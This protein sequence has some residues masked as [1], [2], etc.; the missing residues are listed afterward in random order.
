LYGSLRAVKV[1]LAALRSTIDCTRSANGLA[2]KTSRAG[3][4][5][6]TIEP[7][8]MQ[9]HVQKKIKNFAQA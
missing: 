2:P 3:N 5:L 9:K 8:D 1:L 7:G 4:S 6:P